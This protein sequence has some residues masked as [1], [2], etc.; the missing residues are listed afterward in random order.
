MQLSP[1][2]PV[3]CG[4]CRAKRTADS[5]SRVNPQAP[6][7]G[8]TAVFGACVCHLLSVPESININDG[9]KYFSLS[10]FHFNGR[11]TVP[12]SMCF[13]HLSM[14][15]VRKKKNERAVSICPTF[16]MKSKCR[17]DEVHII[18]TKCPKKTIQYLIGWT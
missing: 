4:E 9:W 10:T 7:Y 18:V 12:P 17:N 1:G 8:F 6:H 16:P 14:N 2:S 3:I 15:V 5:G 11:E 13:S